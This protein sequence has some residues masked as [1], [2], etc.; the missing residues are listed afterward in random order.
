MNPL[1]LPLTFTPVYHQLVWGG[2]RMAQWRPDLPAGAIGES[3]DLADHPRGM[4]V[5]SAGP[6]VGRSLRQ[7][8]TEFGKRLVGETYDGGDFPLLVKLIDAN[9]RL[10]VQVHPDDELAV[11]LGVGKRGKTECWL[12]VADGGELYV[13]T[14]PGCT[15]AGFEAALASGR[16]ADELNL[17]QAKDG[18]FFFLAAR[19]V[20]A[21]G[22]G[23]LLYEVQQTCDVTFR[24]D[25]WGRV[26]LDGKPRPLHVAESLAT[27]DF[28]AHGSGAALTAEVEHPGGGSVRRLADCRYFA[29]EERRAQRTSGGGQGRC[30]LVTCL[31]GHGQLCTAA[32]AIPIEPMRTYLVPAEAGPWNAIARTV[33]YGTLDTLLGLRLLVATPG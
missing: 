32:G 29:V 5:V 14:R 19:T 13:G 27:I 21:L 12:M 25:D 3:W 33:E 9:D 8:C 24:V 7:L 22:R 15:R 20:H 16:V 11:S 31:S 18:D 30:N 17:H 28:G 1:A 23:C 10:S 6:L 2:R 26:G 4:S